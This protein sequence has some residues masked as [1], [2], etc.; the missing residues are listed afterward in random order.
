MSNK[1]ITA[2][3]SADITPPTRK[4]VMLFMADSMNE[5]TGR[6]NPSIEA[7]ARACGI[8][9]DMARRHLHD[10]IQIGLI[11]VVGNPYGGAP[12]ATRNYRLNLPSTTGMDATPCT[13]ATPGTHAGDALHPCSRPLAPMQETTGTHASQTRRNQKEPEINQK[14]RREKRATPI[15]CPPDVDRQVWADWSALRKAKRAP[16]TGTVINGARSE[17]A[18]AGM[19]LNDFLMEWCHRGSQGLKAEWIT[20]SKQLASNAAKPARPSRHSGFEKI[21]YREG[22]NDDGSF[23]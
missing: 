10:L 3:W 15:E 2:V 9:A 13:D 1:A 14:V 12:G 5:A 22:I 21:D 18:K 4:L 6:L 16:I 7:V 23:S 19:T 8:S 17:A 11:D 20:G